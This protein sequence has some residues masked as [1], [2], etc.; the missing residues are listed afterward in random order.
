MKV[1]P[2]NLY[3]RYG[4]VR[5]Y[6]RLYACAKVSALI[7]GAIGIVYS[8]LPEKGTAPSGP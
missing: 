3:F 4:R 5:L 6:R 2:R 8:N 7:A 1:L